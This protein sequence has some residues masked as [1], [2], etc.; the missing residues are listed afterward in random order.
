MSIEDGRCR[1]CKN[2]SAVVRVKRQELCNRCAA[3]GRKVLEKL[4]RANAKTQ[5]QTTS[6]SK[7]AV[8]Q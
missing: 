3:R 6:D 4:A 5:H 7:V 2:P 1:I 8:N